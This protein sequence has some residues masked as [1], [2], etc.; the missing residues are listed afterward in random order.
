MD[1]SPIKQ[2]EV[3]IE[4]LKFCFSG[5]G[6]GQL[7]GSLLYTLEYQIYSISSISRISSILGPARATEHIYYHNVPDLTPKRNR[8]TG[9]SGCRGEHGILGVLDQFFGNICNFNNRSM[10]GGR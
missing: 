2:N 7:M 3:P 9:N 6:Y 4:I 8:N 5:E 10:T 1:A